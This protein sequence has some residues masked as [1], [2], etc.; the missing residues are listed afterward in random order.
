MHIVN[1]NYR[2]K[3]EVWDLSGEG[4]NEANETIQIPKKLYDLWGEVIP[5]R[6][7]EYVE[8]D[9]LVPEMQHKITTRYRPNLFQ[10]IE[11]NIEQY[12]DQAMIIMWQGRKLNIKAI[13]DISGREEEME[14]MCIEKVETNE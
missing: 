14:I 3:L 4:K 9:K 6:G 5:V 7:K 8:M 12:I 10:A 11:Q 13:V 2:H 1:R